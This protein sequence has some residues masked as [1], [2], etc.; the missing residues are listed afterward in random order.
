MFGFDMQ[1]CL[2]MRLLASEWSDQHRPG[3]PVD[4]A[5]FARGVSDDT[6]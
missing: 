3:Y 6:P 4:A 2:T 5:K 1:P